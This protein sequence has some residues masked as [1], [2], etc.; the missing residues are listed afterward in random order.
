MKRNTEKPKTLLDRAIAEVR[1]ASASPEQVEIAASR[2]LQN[3]HNEYN[4]VVAHPASSVSTGADRIQSCDDFRALI[5]AYLSSSLT[6]S[7]LLLLED[8]SRECVGCRRAIEAAKRGVLTSGDPLLAAGTARSARSAR[9]GGGRHFRWLAPVAAVALLALAIQTS[10]IRDLLWPIEIHATVQAVDGGLYNVSGQDVRVIRSGERIDRQQPVR[11]GNDSGAVLELADGSRIEMAARSELSLDRARDGV[12]IK[13]ERGNVIV[14]AAKQ[15]SGHL[16][17]ETSDCTV[18]VVGTL[19]SVNAGVKGSRVIVVEGEV[20]VEHAGMSQSVRP[21]QQAFTNPEMG[22]VPLDQEL[23]W[24][25]DAEAL[26]REIA[27]FGQ[28]FAKRV[29]GS[30]MRFTSNLAGLVPEDTLVFASLPNVSQPFSESY[31]LFRR[32][33]AENP[34]LASWWQQNDGDPGRIGVDEIAQR[35]T[36]LGGYLGQEVVLAFP[37]EMKDRSPLLLAETSR[38]DDLIRVLEDDIARLSKQNPEIKLARNPQELAALSGPG[39]AILV[40]DGLMVVADATQVKRV[41]ALRQGR[42]TNG[43][44]GTPL[45]SR[46]EQAYR[47]GVGWLLAADV[48]QMVPADVRSSPQLGISDV[49]QLVI[50]Q[51]TG[52]GSAASRAT[53]G[54]SQ[55]RQGLAAWLAPAAPMGA[56][57]FVSPDAYAVSAVIVKDPALILD[58]VFALLRDNDDARKDIEDFQQNQRVDLRRDLAE[59]LGNE[60]LVAVDGPVLPTPS[61]RVVIEVNDAPRLE[62]AIQWTVTNLNREAQAQGRSEIAIASET[63]EGRTF[64]KLTSANFPAGIH[65]TFWVGYMIVAPSRA[66]LIETIRNHDSGNTLGR[67]AEFRAEMPA[68]GR[69]HFSAFMYQNIQAMTKSVPSGPLNRLLGHDVN[70]VLANAVPRVVAVYGEPDRIVTSA[71]GAFGVNLASMLG[72]QGMLQSAGFFNR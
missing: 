1:S 37:K 39:L 70:D 42:L 41:A 22:A 45:Y 23:G 58:D 28:D 16:Y 62:N 69:D 25:R 15:R 35:F 46:L 63:V 10:S 52:P 59:P 4:K 48:R 20:N 26:L 27:M 17:L 14:T 8:H 43:F 54:F 47:E 57:E 49:Q 34:T 32:R 30:S 65:Y 11:T 3:L 55:N 67:S 18:S 7:R 72:L 40:S 29:E 64:N 51:K 66:L 68:D 5:P 71:K 13:L 2:V 21:G 19:F 36:E 53:L 38:P 60:F 61:W 56:L 6:P 44:V 24:S 50:E 31:A 33:V 9:R 12:K